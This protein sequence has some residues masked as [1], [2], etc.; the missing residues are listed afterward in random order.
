M[1]APLFKSLQR[2]RF[3]HIHIHVYDGVL[4]V[5]VYMYTFSCDV[6]LCR[7]MSCCVIQVPSTHG[8]VKPHSPFDAEEDARTLRT[9][10]K[11]FGKSTPKP[12]LST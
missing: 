12:N 3:V 7:E 2:P 10:M 5:Y 11:G 8:T 4:V 9:A 6:I 1:A